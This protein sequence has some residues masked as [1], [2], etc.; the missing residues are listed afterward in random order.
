MNTDNKLYENKEFQHFAEDILRPGGAEL[1]LEAVKLAGFAKGD[2]LLD[3]GCGVGKTVA[4]LDA[5]YKMS[6]IDISEALIAKGKKL[7]PA[8]DIRVGTA[9]ALPYEKNS[10]DGILAECVLSLLEDKK[11]AFKEMKRV[12]RAEGKLVA[13]DLYIRES[14]KPFTGLPLVTCINGMKS[15]AEIKQ[16]MAENGFELLA[17]QDKTLLFK[18]FLAGLIMNYGSMALFWQSLVN[19]CS[20]ACTI[21]ES[22][23][24]IKIGYYLA[25]W[26]KG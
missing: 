24:G 18:G 17:W 21:Q 25:V 7:A 26:Q 14:T 20:K 3:L 6:G 11:A 16:E 2:M 10:F 23:Q 5:M 22:L 13:S 9:Y 12:L 8:L 19:D 15:E 1:S 4:N